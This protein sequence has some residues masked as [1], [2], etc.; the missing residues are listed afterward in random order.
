MGTGASNRKKK[1]QEIT[2]LKRG[3]LILHF[4]VC[5]QVLRSATAREKQVGKSLLCLQMELHE[6][7]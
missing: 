1:V 2:T 3:V 4:T 6:I 7:K 5:L